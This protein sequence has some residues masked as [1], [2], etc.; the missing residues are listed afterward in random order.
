MLEA[1][2]LD[3]LFTATRP[4]A[5]L[6]G[7]RRIHRL[8]PNYVEVEQD[9]FRRT[10]HF[11]IMH[12]AVV[13]GAIYREHPWVAES[14]VRAFARA[15]QLGWERLQDASMLAVML[16]WLKAA[17]EDSLAGQGPRLWQYGF[18]ANYA[19]LQA[20]CAYHHEQGLSERRLTPEELFPVETQTL[21]L[22]P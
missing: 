1:G 12:L 14:L 10:G 9:Y 20:M 7:S 17:L 18:A 6:D 22:D 13:R 16:P 11:P 4:K 3:A 15:Q 5:F 8:F 21:V 19:T 2:T